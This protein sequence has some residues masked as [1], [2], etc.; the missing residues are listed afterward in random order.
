MC[1]YVCVCVGG[2]GGYSP[3][4]LIGSMA[5]VAGKFPIYSPDIIYLD[6]SKTFDKVPHQGLIKKIWRVMGLRGMS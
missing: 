2:G 4:T 5:F 1:V 6:F 3:A